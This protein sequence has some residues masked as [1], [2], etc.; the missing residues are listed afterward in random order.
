M[1]SMKNASK[2]LNTVIASA[3]RPAM[4]TYWWRRLGR[5]ALITRYS[6]YTYVLHPKHMAHRT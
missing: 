6:S 4:K 2:Q 1:Q 5:A 3:S